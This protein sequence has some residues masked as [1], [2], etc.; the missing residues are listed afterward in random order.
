MLR[1]YWLTSL[2][3]FHWYIVSLDLSIDIYHYDIWHVSVTL[4]RS[5]SHFITLA[6][7]HNRGIG[8]L[9]YHWFEY[10]ISSIHYGRHFI[11][12]W[13]R[14]FVSWGVWSSVHYHRDEY[15]FVGPVIRMVSIIAWTSRHHQFFH[16]TG[17]LHRDTSISHRYRST[18]YRIGSVAGI[19]QVNTP[20]LVWI[21]GILTISYCLS[22]SSVGLPRRR[23]RR[24]D[25]SVTFSFWL[26]YWPT[27]N[28]IFWYWLD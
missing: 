9:D 15:R 10:R 7:W 28:I 3:F 5:I 11:S 19:D 24:A 27:L 16:T 2:F 25:L 20:G 23:L 1:H 21:L 4:L 12:H 14:V 8:L 13:T 6:D 22:T 26:G 17:S 18:T